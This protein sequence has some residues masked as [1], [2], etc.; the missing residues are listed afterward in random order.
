M[1]PELSWEMEKKDGKL[2]VRYTVKNSGTSPIWVVDDL[3]MWSQTAFARAPRAVVV[4]QGDAP[5]T[6]SFYRGMLYIPS[7]ERRQYPSPGVREVAAGA[8]ISAELET[9]LPLVAWH[10]YHPKKMKPLDGAPSQAV[11][12]IQYLTSRGDDGE[13]DWSEVKLKDGS[14]LRYPHVRFLNES[15]KLVRSGPKPLPN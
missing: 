15:A 1:E 12:E 7:R 5:G 10:Y 13:R 14:S 3:L 4:R 11:L 6:V 2:H 8:E 9:A